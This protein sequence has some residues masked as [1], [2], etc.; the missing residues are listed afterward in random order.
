MISTTRRVE[1]VFNWIE[2]K[3]SARKRTYDS[4]TG[5][6]TWLTEDIT[7]PDLP[8][9]NQLDISIQSNEK[10]DIRIKSISEV[11]WPES[12]WWNLIG[13]VLLLLIFLLI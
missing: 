2:F 11:G 3:S 1:Q 13:L 12:L 4:S 10:I 8:N 9:I 7:N 6:Y 5:V